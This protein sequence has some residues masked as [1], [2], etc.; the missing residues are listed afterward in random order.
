MKLCNLTVP[1]WCS[2]ESFGFSECYV[3]YNI[4]LTVSTE[5]NIGKEIN[6]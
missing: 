5:N 3:N 2:Y 4:L 1:H 6:P